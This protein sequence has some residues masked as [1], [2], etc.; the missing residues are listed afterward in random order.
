MKDEFLQQY[1]FNFNPYTREWNGFLRE[2]YI[3]YFNGVYDNVYT[4]ASISK[5]IVKLKNVSN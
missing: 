2:H 1:V 4:D 3:E 5:L